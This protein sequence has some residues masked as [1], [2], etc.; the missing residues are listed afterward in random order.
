MGAYDPEIVGSSCTK[1]PKEVYPYCRKMPAPRS[2]WGHV[3]E[4][5]QPGS[6]SSEQEDA[7]VVP[8]T[9]SGSKSAPI[10]KAPG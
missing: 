7:K 1:D 5:G 10:S 4:L 9:A 3:A 8:V 6:R 2:A